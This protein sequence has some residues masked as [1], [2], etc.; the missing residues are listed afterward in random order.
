MILPHMAREQLPLALRARACTDLRAAQEHGKASPAQAG[1]MADS[2]DPFAA[3]ELP[4][5]LDLA[6]C[7]SLG[8]SPFGQRRNPHDQQLC[9]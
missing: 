9:S 1:V 3:F 7:A 4:T 6:A 2:A 5:R 8:A